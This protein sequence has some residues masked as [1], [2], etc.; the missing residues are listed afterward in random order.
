[1]EYL[2]SAL[3]Q[4]LHLG[5]ARGSG[6][7]LRNAQFSILNTRSYVLYVLAEAGKPDRGR[8][9]ALFEQRAQL[10][11]Y[12]RAY[13][14]MTLKALGGEDTRERTLVGDLMGTA[15]LHTADAHWEEGAIDY[16]TM[17]SNTRTTALALQALVRSDP[18]NFLVPN[19]VRYLMGLRDHG[20]WSTTQESAATLMALSEYI[21]QSG[22]LEADYTYRAALDGRTLSEGAINRDNLDDPVSIVF[23]L[24]EL[25]AG[26]S[27][28]LALQRQAATSQT[29]KG[30]L[31]YTLRMRYYEDAASV[32]ALDKGIGVQRE[33]VAVDTDTLSPTGQLVTQAGL[34]DLVQV[35]LTLVV[36]EDMPYFAV[37]D[38]LPAGLEALDTSL[39]TV[40]DAAQSPDLSEAGEDRPYWWYFSQTEIRDNRVALFAT[41]LPKG[42]YHYTYLARATT[43]GTFQ[44]LPALAYRMYSPEVFGRSAGARFVVTGN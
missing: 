39:K 21:A 31:Y 11:I 22:E 34:G 33:Y 8:T 27:S 44:T 13:L 30:R 43:A 41:D 7:E 23:G 2:E 14:L 4:E 10:Q 35:R 28:Q 42:T 25:K 20:H 15:I 1:M 32:Q 29:G 37:E 5:N 38:M 3:D 16:W 26:G 36:P 9:I 6:Q 24:A 40:S 19:A 17:S 12:G 18:G